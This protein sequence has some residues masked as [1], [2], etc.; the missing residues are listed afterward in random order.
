[1]AVLRYGG[2][3]EPFTSVYAPP[4]AETIPQGIH[5]RT[6]PPT[7]CRRVVVPDDVA[8]Q[9]PIVPA[10]TTVGYCSWPKKQGPG[11]GHGGHVR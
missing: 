7:R 3:K 5:V 8:R 11:L 4:D 1:M 9:T 6:R 2:M 10:D